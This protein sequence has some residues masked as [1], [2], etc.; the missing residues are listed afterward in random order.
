[1]E[2]SPRHRPIR[3]APD[4][5]GQKG[6]V[7]SATVA[8]LDRQ[9]IFADYRLAEG[10]V[11]VLH[12][13]AD[14]YGVSVYAFCIMP[15]H[16]HLVLGPSASC[17]VVAFI[18]QFKNLTLRMAWQQGVTGTF[19]QKSFWDHFVRDYEDLLAKVRYVLANPQR[20]GLVDEWQEYP[21]S[22]SLVYPKAQLR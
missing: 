18:G 10:A 14:K 16:V 7:C 8:V 3:L 5:Y 2:R 13:L 17:D 6:S 21:F 19:W 20:K 9:P 11:G 22:G 4:L 12:Q 15:D 1:M